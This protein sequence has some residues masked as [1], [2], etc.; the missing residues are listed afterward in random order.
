MTRAGSDQRGVAALEFALVLPFLL[1]LLAGAVDVG[2]A[3]MLR[4]Q[5]QEGAQEAVTV[6]ARS[7]QDTAL[8]RSRAIDSVS[9][10]DLSPSDID[11]TC[12]TQRRTRVTISHEYGTII[13]AGVL[14][15]AAQLHLEVDTVSDVLAVPDCSGPVT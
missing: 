11:I 13:L 4:A 5:I 14:P 7:P 1:L 6:V 9:A 2:T 3:L 10:T 12:D 8:A 15:G